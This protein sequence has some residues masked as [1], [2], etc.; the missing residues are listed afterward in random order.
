M[1]VPDQL[2]G[3]VPAL[4]EA[5]PVHHV[6][7]AALQDLE[8]VVAG[9]TVL[10]GGLFV[11]VVELPLQHAVH[12][13]GLLL[14]ADLKEVLA[15]LRTVPA[16]LARRVRPDLNRALRRVALR[17]LEEQLHLLAPAA[18]AVRTSVSSH[19]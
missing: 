18:L 11:V 14:L 8:Q 3:H 15:L 13:A 6:V 16:V 7:Q 2:A 10:A 9:T 5:G 1:A 12:A 19:V 17:A 4:G